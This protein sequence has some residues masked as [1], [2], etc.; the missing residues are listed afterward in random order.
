VSAGRAREQHYDIATD[1]WTGEEGACIIA[2]CGIN[3]PKWPAHAHKEIGGSIRVMHSTLL[4]CLCPKAT[5]SAK[6]ENCEHFSEMDKM[7]AAKSRERERRICAAWTYADRACARV[8]HAIHR[9]ADATNSQSAID[10]RAAVAAKKRRLGRVAGA[11][12][13]ESATERAQ[14]CSHD[15]A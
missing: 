13:G 14:L 9:P 7:A 2:S 5:N 3:Q 15:V 8:L 1:G 10:A 6:L 11:I 4:N 12:I